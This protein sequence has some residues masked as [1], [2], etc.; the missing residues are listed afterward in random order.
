M[1]KIFTLLVA[2]AGCWVGVCAQ[3]DEE[4]DDS[5]QFV[6]ASGEIIANGS[7]IIMNNV[8]KE[9]DPFSG[10]I[11]YKIPADFQVKNVSNTFGEAVRLFMSITQIDN[12]EFS[13]CALGNCIPPKSEV[14][15]LYTS[16]QVLAMGT[17]SGDLLTEWYAYDYG[18]CV[19]EMQME[20]G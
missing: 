14:C 3:D 10:E 1:K 8:E 12:G 13:T 4:I 2:L 17:T 15:D 7:T 19:V 11:L 18:K 16:A 6:T 20:I 9:E 5:Y